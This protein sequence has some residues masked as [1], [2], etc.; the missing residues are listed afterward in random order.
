MSPHQTK[1]SFYA[2]FAP[3]DACDDACAL[4]YLSYVRV[5]IAPN[6]LLCY[7]Y[8]YDGLFPSYF[9]RNH[10]IYPFQICPLQLFCDHERF[11]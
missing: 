1:I 10:Y 5:L 3:F 2:S 6:H 4:P 11:Q 9:C 7:P 8:I